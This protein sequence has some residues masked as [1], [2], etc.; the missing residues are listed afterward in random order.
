MIK[1]LKQYFTVDVVLGNLNIKHI[2]TLLSVNSNAVFV[3]WQTEFLAPWLTSM[4]H[5]VVVF[6]MYDGCSGAPDNYFK[7]LDHAY[8]FNFSKKLHKRSTD[9]G[10]VSYQLSWY[11]ERKN[12]D[13]PTS[14]DDRLF[15]W[16]RRPE[17]SLSESVIL[18]YFSPYVGSFHIHDR[19]DNYELKKST[20][21]IP[22]GYISTSNWFDEKEDLLSLVASSKY[23]LAPRETEGIGL[24]FLEAMRD[25]CIVFANKSATHDQYIYDGYNGFLIDFISNDKALIQKQIKKAFKLIHSGKPIGE[26]AR[27]FNRKGESIWNKQSQKILNVLKTIDKSESLEPLSR[28]EQKLGYLLARLFYVHPKMYFVFSDLVVRLGFFSDKSIKHNIF[29]FAYGFLVRSF[30]I[31]NRIIGRKKRT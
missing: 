25:G 9:V 24:A 2:Q 3:L 23:Y 27:E 14:K 12:T 26:N 31:L 16:L 1:L 6:P 20:S 11:P 15:Y 7:I 4:G 28:R 17:S 29:K 5:K 18:D 21:L 30:A 10:V 22:N 19:P 8:L 13:K